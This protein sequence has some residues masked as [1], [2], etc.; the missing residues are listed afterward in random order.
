MKKYTTWKKKDG[1]VINI[2]DMSENHIKSCMNMLERILT[3]RPF[4]N[5]NIDRAVSQLF[6]FQEELKKRKIDSLEEFQKQKLD[7]VIARL[8]QLIEEEESHE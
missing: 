7:R 3:M 8:N 6:S 5:K 4:F 1:T 2:S